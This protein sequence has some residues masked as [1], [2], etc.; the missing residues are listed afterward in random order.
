MAFLVREGGFG[1]FG[2]RS[3]KKCANVQMRKCA[4]EKCANVQMRK[5]R[6]GGT[7]CADVQMKI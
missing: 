3:A 6:M 4:D 2:L 5:S 1:D 7:S